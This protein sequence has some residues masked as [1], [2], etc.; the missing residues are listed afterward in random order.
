MSREKLSD[1]LNQYLAGTISKE[2]LRVLLDL[3]AIDDQRQVEPIIDK[4]IKEKGPLDD[5][6]EHF[7]Q[8]AV[9][10]SIRRRICSG[11]LPGTRWL[12]AGIATFLVILSVLLYQNSDKK[13]S[14]HQKAIASDIFLPEK[15]HVILRLTDGT[16]YDLSQAPLKTLNE[17]G[18]NI[19]TEEDGQTR[20]VFTP[21]SIEKTG[22][23]TIK[24]GKG[25]TCQLQLTDGSRIWLNAGA[26]LSYPSRF[27]ESRRHVTLEGEAFFQVAHDEHR[28]FNV[29]TAHTVV[30][31]LGTQFNIA[32][33]SSTGFTH[34]TLVEGSVAVTNGNQT[35]LLQPGWQATTEDTTP[36]ILTDT[37]NLRDVLAWKDGYFRFN[38]HTIAEV[39]AQVAAWYGIE[40][41]HI[42]EQTGDRF[43]GSVSKAQKLSDVL[44]QLTEISNYRFKI[45]ERSVY[46][47][48]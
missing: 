5:T 43:T 27:P 25:H 8:G 15:N 22:F 37:V 1:L 21:A 24:N 32:A 11:Y 38:D 9:M 16:Q 23:Y 34:T 6:S 20:F 39:M 46:I 40:H 12:A 14:I 18:V 35:R 3:M 45:K 29:S 10:N 2:D 7:N 31:V 13:V 44:L 48:K 28:P 30:Q 17:I 47:M 42:D 36:G 41:I 4:L 26:T 19:V 33:D